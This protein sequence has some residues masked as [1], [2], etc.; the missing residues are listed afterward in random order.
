MVA[1]SNPDAP[2]RP[3]RTAAPPAGGTLVAVPRYP[4][5]TLTDGRL[6]L[7]PPR[8]GDIPALVAACQDPEIPRWTRVPSPYTEEHARAWLATEV[9]GVR[10]FVVDGED[11]L[12]G[13]VA[14]MEVDPARGYAEIGYWVAAEARRRGVATGAVTLL[15]DWAAGELG[16]TLIEL[17]VHRD[18]TASLGVPLRAGFERTG[19]L[20]DAPARMERTTGPVYVVFAWS[21]T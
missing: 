1:G 4:Q 3:R 14:L 7:R 6:T 12:L 9:E 8:A 5:P 10:L 17:L 16:L 15:R 18:N 19:E 21:A 13:T 11:R 20:R 2:H